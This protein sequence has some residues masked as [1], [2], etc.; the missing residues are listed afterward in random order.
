M[1]ELTLMEHGE[2]FPQLM[3][4]ILDRF[5]CKTKLK[6]KL[7]FLNW[8][9]AWAELVRVGLYGD[10]P[11]VSEIGSTWLSEFVSMGALRP[12]QLAE[13]NSLGGATQFLPSAWQSVRLSTNTGELDTVWAVPWVSDTRL[14]YYR[15]DVFERVGVDAQAVFQTPHSLLAACAQFQA[16]GVPNPIVLP[17]R[18]THITLH[19]IASWVWNSG[20][21]FL[22]PRQRKVQFDAPAVRT[23]IQAYF[24]LVRFMSPE[25][26][27]LDDHGMHAAYRRGDAASVLTGTWLPGTLGT[28]PEIQAHTRYTLPPGVPYLGGSHL[29]VWKHTRQ[30]APVLALVSYLASAEV[31]QQFVQSIGLL[32]T[33][34]DVLSQGIF[35]HDPFY[36]RVTEGLKQARAFPAFPLWGM[37]ENRL[38]EAFMT[39]WSEVLSSPAPEIHAIVDKHLLA[40]AKRLN[41]TLASY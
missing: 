38:T 14:I 39:I 11:Q 36:Q 22:L 6:V 12:F 21:D 8:R 17:T 40:T 37:V 41:A 35:L 32:P 25:M 34:L 31:Q 29:V 3:Q 18:F 9:E 27:N 7:R 1:I 19:N 16:A 13:L 20:G 26:R 33:R 5:E 4:E 28:V 30:S 23:S 15:Q 24:D 10:G 2:H